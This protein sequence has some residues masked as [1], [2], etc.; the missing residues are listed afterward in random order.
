MKGP[1]GCITGMLIV[2]LSVCLSASLFVCS[3]MNIVLRLIGAELRVDINLVFPTSLFTILGLQ[4]TWIDEF[5][6]V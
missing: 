2:G 1:V 3:E 4:N 6:V 5:Y